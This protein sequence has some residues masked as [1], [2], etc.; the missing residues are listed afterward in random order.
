[1]R[2]CVIIGLLMALML[3][4]AVVVTVK[5]LYR[6]ITR[7]IENKRDE[8]LKR[9][10]MEEDLAKKAHNSQIPSQSILKKNQ[11]GG[12]NAR[13]APMNNKNTL[14]INHPTLKDVSF[15]SQDSYD[16]NQPGTEASPSQLPAYNDAH[17]YS[18]AIITTNSHNSNEFLQNPLTP[19]QLS[20]TSSRIKKEDVEVH[21]EL[22]DQ[23]RRPK[24]KKKTKTK[25]IESQ[26]DAQMNT[27]SHSYI[28]ETYDGTEI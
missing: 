26:D 12:S 11:T 15:S 21:A 3:V 27:Q 10:Q 16:Y 8:R 25:N 28:Q 19:S 7:H 14:T 22:L 20:V 9:Q 24:K 13:K 6:D 5:M 1:M 23:P 18:H 2:A 4:A 17:N